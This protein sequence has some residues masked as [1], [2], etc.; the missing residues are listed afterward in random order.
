MKDLTSGG[1]GGGDE[2]LA[3]SAHVSSSL[4][5]RLGE[6]TPENSGSSSREAIAS[7]GGKAELW[8]WS[9][10]RTERAGVSGPQMARIVRGRYW[11][12]KRVPATQGEEDLNLARK[13]DAKDS[14]QPHQLRERTE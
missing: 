7:R 14:S 6:A 11:A 13:E 5:K 3:I 8:A 9:T 4:S 12:S 2:S 1:G 10:T